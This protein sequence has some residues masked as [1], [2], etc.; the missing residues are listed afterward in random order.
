MAEAITTAEA[1]RFDGSDAMT[2]ARNKAF[3]AGITDWVSGTSTLDEAL[4][5]IEAAS[6]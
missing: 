6:Q 4:G 3:W 5:E 2:E 1:A